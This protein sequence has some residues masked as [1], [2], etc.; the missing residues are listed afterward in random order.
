MAF[1]AGIAAGEWLRFVRMCS[2]YPSVPVILFA[3]VLLFGWFIRMK[4][5]DVVL[6]FAGI[7]ALVISGAVA[8]YILF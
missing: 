1:I 3:F 7:S 2:E 4:V 8:T 6:F 5:Q